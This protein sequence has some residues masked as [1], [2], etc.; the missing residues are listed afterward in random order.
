MAESAARLTDEVLPEQPVRQW[1]LSFPFPLRFLFVSQPAIMGRVLGIVYRAIATHLIHKAGYTRK[2]AH[3]GAVTLIQ[4]S[5]IYAGTKLGRS[6]TSYE[7]W[8]TK[9]KLMN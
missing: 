5:L 2:T 6:P 8:S 1:V 7:F 3:T 9:W 4:Y